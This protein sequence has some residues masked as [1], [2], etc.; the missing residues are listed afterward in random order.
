MIG[1]KSFRI[2]RTS[3]KIKLKVL[4]KT[5]PKKKNF[6]SEIKNQT[7]LLQTTNFP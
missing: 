3:L 1:I 5:K 2:Q 4:L 7:T 6:K